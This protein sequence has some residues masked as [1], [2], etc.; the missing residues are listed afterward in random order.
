MAKT[1]KTGS[2][3]QSKTIYS[4]AQPPPP[5]VFGPSDTHQFQ[6]KI[7]NAVLYAHNIFK[8]TAGFQNIIINGQI[9]VGGPGC[10]TGPKLES[11]INT[12][13]QTASMTENDAVLRDAIA[14]GISECF[15]RWRQRVTV[16]GLPWYPSFDPWPGPMAAPTPNV[17]FQLI[18]CAS[19]GILEITSSSLLASECI[20]QLNSQQRT[21][22]EKVS[23]INTVATS[24]STFFLSWLGKQQVTSVMGT[25]PVPGFAPPYVPVG[26]VVNGWVLPGIHLAT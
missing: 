8:L 20:N 2:L 11:Y 16:P 1:I 24:L 9:A 10:L 14:K 19:S 23:L 7:Y 25:G 13:P 21:A 3:T 6:D 15:D 4:S 17:P 5:A 26:H 12:A 18:A 22:K